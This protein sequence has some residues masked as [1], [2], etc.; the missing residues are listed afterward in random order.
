MQQRENRHERADSGSLKEAP[1]LH[2]A[3]EILFVRHEGNHRQRGQLG[4]SQKL[5]RR[6]YRMVERFRGGAGADSA[7]EGQNKSQKHNG[8]PVGL[9]RLLRQ[10]G[11]ID[12]RK[13]FA[14]SI[15]ERKND[16]PSG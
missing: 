2:G 3:G 4:E 15:T 8:G 12:E 9:V 16:V 7:G 11:R 6:A 5:F 1:A 14:F 13:P 10:A